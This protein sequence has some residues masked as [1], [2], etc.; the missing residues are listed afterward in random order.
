MD[1]TV[2]DNQH[3]L[4]DNL[5]LDLGHF[6]GLTK[7]YDIADSNNE[8]ELAKIP[9]NTWTHLA[10]TYE[11]AKGRV[12]MYHDGAQIGEFNNYNVA[13]TDDSNQKVF[14]GKYNDNVLTNDTLLSDITVYDKVFTDGQVKDLYNNT[15]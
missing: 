10:A 11:S 4:I 5:R 15:K 2:D 12:K 9:A 3:V 8:I 1:K 7:F 14:I 6:D 13:P